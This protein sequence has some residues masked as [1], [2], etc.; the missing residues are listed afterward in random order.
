[1]FRVDNR[2]TC[3]DCGY[4]QRAGLRVSRATSRRRSTASCIRMSR[5]ADRANDVAL[6]IKPKAHKQTAIKRA[7]DHDARPERDDDR[8][9]RARHLVQARASRAST[10]CSCRRTTPAERADAETYNSNYVYFD[11][12]QPNAKAAAQQL[13]VAMGPHTIA[14]PAAARD[15]AVRAAGGE[16]ARGRR[17]RHGVRRRAR[18]SAGARRRRRRCTSRAVRDRPGRDARPLQA[19]RGEGAVPRPGAERHRASSRLAQLEPGARL[20]AGARTSTSSCSRSSRATATSTGRSSRP[21]GR[22]LRSSASRRG[23]IT[24]KGRKFQLFTNGGH[25]HMVVLRQGKASY[26]VVN[27]LRDELSNETMLA[28]AKGLRPFGK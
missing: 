16:S 5:L 7:A 18:Q 22:A 6:G 23:K 10:R 2:R 4:A 1:M 26:W 14:R 28:I 19:V 8:R 25:I 9:P 15:R 3:T 24:L 13:K 12:V 17:R 20:Q 21:T 27:T 11:A